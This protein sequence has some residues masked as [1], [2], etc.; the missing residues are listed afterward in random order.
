MLKSVNKIL[1][2]LAN[3]QITHALYA[4]SHAPSCG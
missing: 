4:G 2:S 3:G 1:V